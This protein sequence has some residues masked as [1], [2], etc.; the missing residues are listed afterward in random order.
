MAPPV[1]SACAEEGDAF[2]ERS[3]PAGCLLHLVELEVRA[4]ELATA[5]EHATEFANLDTQLREDASGGWY[6]LG[7]VAMHLGRI[8][9]ARRILEEGAESSCQIESTTWLAHHVW[10]L[11]HLDLSVGDLD[12][13][14]ARP[15]SA[16]GQSIR[17]T[18]T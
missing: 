14:C 15:G 1:G 11:G 8:E 4:G 6:P 10:A 18:P 9:E 12:G 2:R 5:E 3:R 16:S 7:V 17:F 13:A